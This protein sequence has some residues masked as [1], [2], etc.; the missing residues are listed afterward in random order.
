MAHKGEK[1][2]FRVIFLFFRHFWAI[3]SY[4]GPWAIV[5]VSTDFSHLR[6][7]A[8]LTRPRETVHSRGDILEYVFWMS[9][10]AKVVGAKHD[11]D[12]S[13][14]ELL[15]GRSFVLIFLSVESQALPNPSPP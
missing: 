13:V 2:G 15:P 7:L 12:L 1:M 14:T 10:L 3:F 8:G 4:F 5:H 6:R 11:E 9:P